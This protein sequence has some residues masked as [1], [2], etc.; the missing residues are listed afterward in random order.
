MDCPKEQLYLQEGPGEF[1]ENYIKAADPDQRWPPRD[2]RVMV[3][4]FEEAC[5]LRNW[6][7]GECVGVQ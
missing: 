6:Y 3:S 2:C 1:P 7:E 5:L 4:F